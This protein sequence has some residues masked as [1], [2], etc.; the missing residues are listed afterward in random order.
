MTEQSENNTKMTSLRG[1]LLIA[2]PSLD[3]PFFSRSVT[4]LCEHNEDGAMGLM[5]NHPVKLTL[6]ELLSQIE[7]V[8]RD[9][10]DEPELTQ[11]ILSGGPVNTDRG[12]VLHTRQ[13]GWASSQELGSN[14]MVTT[15]K[16]VLEVLGTPA[17]PE[18]YLVTLGYAGWSA[19]QLEQELAANS[20]LTIPAD[21]A[22]IF[23][24]PTDKLW[25]EATHRL[26]IDVWQISPEAGHA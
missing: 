6:A 3:D 1:S 9:S 5:L 17:A 21:E 13:L 18:K 22:L 16:D 10:Y 12:F 11:P 2:M 8:K 7:S 19:G 23:D 24:T 26:G 20:W 4:Y 14:L 15:S 25:E